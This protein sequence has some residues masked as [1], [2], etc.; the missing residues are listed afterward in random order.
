MFLSREAGVSYLVIKEHLKLV[1]KS[2]HIPFL[3]KV[4]LR[5]YHGCSKLLG[6][7]GRKSDAISEKMFSLAQEGKGE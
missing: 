7:P 1:L 3:S 2:S 5:G 4:N 6:S